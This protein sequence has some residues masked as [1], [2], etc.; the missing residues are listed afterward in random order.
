MRQKEAVISVRP[1]YQKTLCSEMALV[2]SHTEDHHK[3]LYPHISLIKFSYF[4]LSF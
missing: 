3:T 4:G 2:S 1:E